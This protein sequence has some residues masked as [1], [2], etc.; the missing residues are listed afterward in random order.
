MTNTPS[1]RIVRRKTAVPTQQSSKPEPPPEVKRPI[2][3][4]GMPRGGRP[5]KVPNYEGK[6][7]IAERGTIVAEMDLG[8]FFWMWELVEY[9]AL[10]QWLRY[11][12]IDPPLADAA[13]RALKALRKAGHAHPEYSRHYATTKRVVRRKSSDQSPTDS[14]NNIKSSTSS[15]RK[16][17]RRK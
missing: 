8:S 2:D 13:V 3:I 4:D 9:R 1:R 5:P 7:F 6:A 11:K 12:D 15:S 10:E 14:N 16:I 17:V